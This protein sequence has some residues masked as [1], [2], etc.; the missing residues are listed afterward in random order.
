MT[1]HVYTRAQEVLDRIRHMPNPVGVELGVFKGWMSTALLQ[2]HGGLRLFMIDNWLSLERQPQQ[3]RETGD[4]HAN[5]SE[6]EQVN[7]LAAAHRNTLPFHRRRDIIVGEGIRAADLFDDYSLD[8]VFLDADHSFH[9]TMEALLTWEHKVRPGGF[10]S[11]H[12]YGNDFPLGEKG[13]RR[14]YVT[15]AVDEWL[16]QRPKAHGPLQLGKEFTWFTDLI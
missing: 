13:A 14:F 7:N 5:L 2:G 16:E 8:F 4:L 3:Y 11:G 6:S 10:L 15:Q 12:D 1:H 9:G